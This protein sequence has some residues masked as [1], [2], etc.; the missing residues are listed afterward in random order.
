MG[1]GTP[2]RERRGQTRPTPHRRNTSPGAQNGGLG[3]VLGHVMNVVSNSKGSVTRS[4]QPGPRPPRRSISPRGARGPLPPPAVGQARSSLFRL[5]C[6]CVRS[7]P[8]PSLKIIPRSSLRSLQ[9]FL[10]RSHPPPPPPSVYI[11]NIGSSPA[12]PSH[13][14]SHSR[15]RP[16]PPP[17]PRPSPS[18]PSP[19]SPSSSAARPLPLCPSPSLGAGA[20]RLLLLHLGRRVSS[21]FA[22]GD[23]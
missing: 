12:A 8:T 6:A 11:L 7:L 23:S 10:S 1:R 18:S 4:G 20:G 22:A 16:R 15:P 14:W 21:P 2:A 5:V 9:T 3:L 17:L 19:S 13:D